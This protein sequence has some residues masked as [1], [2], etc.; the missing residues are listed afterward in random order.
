GVEAA[1]ANLVEASKALRPV[2]I[3]GAPVRRN[4]RLYN[5]AVVFARGRILGIVPKYRE[6]YE[7]RWFSPGAGV[8]GLEAT[9]AGG[10][11]PF[12]I[13]L[14]FAAAELGDFVFH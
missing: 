12:G 3:V 10:R 6:Y 9:L 7:N 1:L 11:A 4:Q 8:V 14:L 5:C 2:C 13:D